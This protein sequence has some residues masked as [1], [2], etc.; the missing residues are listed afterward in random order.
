MSVV[1]DTEMFFSENAKGFD[2][3]RWVPDRFR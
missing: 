3:F 2:A 1:E